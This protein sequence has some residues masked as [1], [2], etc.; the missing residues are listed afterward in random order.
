[1]RV[2]DNQIVLGA[3]SDVDGNIRF[4]N[5]PVGSYYVYEA[6]APEGYVLDTTPYWIEVTEEG[7]VWEHQGNARPIFITNRLQEEGKTLTF[8]KVDQFGNPVA[9]AEFTLLRASGEAFY[10]VS[11]EDGTVTF[12]GLQNGSYTLRETLAPQ[13]YTRETPSAA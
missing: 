7:V 10:A 3:T 4:E 5:V 13:G 2:S 6:E 1:M 11:Q 8:D 12:A 9:G